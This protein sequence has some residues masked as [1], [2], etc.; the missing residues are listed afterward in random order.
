M[1]RFLCLSLDSSNSAL[2]LDSFSSRTRSFTTS[3]VKMCGCGVEDLPRE[4][5]GSVDAGDSGEHEVDS[6]SSSSSESIVNSFGGSGAE[7]LSEVRERK[8]FR[9]FGSENSFAVR[10]WTESRW[11]IGINYCPLLFL[12][13]ASR[14]RWQHTA[15]AG[16]CVITWLPPN[17]RNSKRLR[18]CFAIQLL[19]K[20]C[21]IFTAA[22]VW[23]PGF[24]LIA[25]LPSEIQMIRLFHYRRDGLSLPCRRHFTANVTKVI[26][27]INTVT[28]LILD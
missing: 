24:V 18:M 12:R 28:S 25:D 20:I 22:Y 23:G 5:Y 14:N 2:P 16:S 17:H 13:D 26:C 21:C 9:R 4:M 7:I 11:Y 19:R 6:P 8:F 15:V 27:T 1:R 3:C 10:N